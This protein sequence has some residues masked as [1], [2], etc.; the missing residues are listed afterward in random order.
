[1]KR[2]LLISIFS[3]F[4]V[5]EVF[6]QDKNP[7]SEVK[8]NE[9]QLS[10]NVERQDFPTEFKLMQLDLNLFRQSLLGA[11]NRLQSLKSNVIISIPNSDG[12]LER[13]QIFEASNFDAQLQ[14]Q[15][16]E[17]RS[18]VGMGIDDKLAIL[19]M[20]VD[21][22]G[23][24][25]MIFRTDKTN[26]FM[27]PYSSDGKVYA[28]YSSSRIKG[29]LP[30]T[31]STQDQN[32]ANRLSEKAAKQSETLRSSTPELLTFRLALSCTAEYSNYF[33]AT[34]ASQVGLVLAAFNATMTRVNGVFEKDFTIRMNIIANTTSVIY[35]TANSDPYSNSNQ[36]NNWNAQLQNT[37]TNVIGEAN[38]DVGHLFGATGG[39]GNAGCIGCVC[40][41]GSKGSGYTS[42]ANGI[43]SGDT[44]DIDY[45]AHE[46]GH[47]FGANH[48]FSHS[49][50]GS[51]VNMEPGSGST[52]MGY[53]GITAQDVQP[54]SNDYFHYA[55]IF[56]VESNMEGKTCPTRTAIA[57][58]DAPIVN[59]GLNYTIPR[60]TP[61]V[62]TGSASDPN[63]VLSY[64][65]EQ[66][67]NAGS[68]QTGV[69]SAASATKATGPN[70]RSYSPVALPL[71]YFPRIQS[72]I[73]NSATTAGTDITVE[74]LS[75]VNRTLNFAFT[76]RDNVA[77]FGLTNTDA[78]TITVNAAAGPFVVNIPSNNGL[79]YAAGTNQTVTWNVAG[80]TANNINASHVDI[81]MS[82]D[83]GFTYPILL[84]TNVPNDGSE[85]VTIPNNVGTSNRIMVKGYNHVFF[86]I[87]NNNFAITA[88]ASTLSL[89]YG[90][91]LGQQNKSI[92]QGN[93]TSYTLDYAALGGFT[94]TTTFT[95]TGNPA[96]TAV[97]FTPS[98]TN[99]NGL[100]T[101]NVT[102]TAAVPLGN[103]TIVVT[104]TS[105]A[106]TKTV[107]LYLTV[108]SG[109][110]GTQALTSP[111]N[112]ATGIATTTSVSWPSN[113]AAT[114][115]VVE[116]ATDI[117]FTNIIA[118]GVITG[119]TTT[120]SGLA[121]ITDY[122]W[123][124]KP[125]NAGCEGTFSAAFKFTTGQSNCTYNYAN[126]TTLAISDGT[127]A[128]TAGPTA[129]K[130]ITVPGTVV[131][132][133]NAV[134]VG[135]SLTH[136][137]VQDLIIELVHP[138]GTIIKLM[139][140]NCDEGATINGASYT[141]NFTNAG[142]F[143]LPNGSCL[144]PTPITGNVKPAD[145]IT[146]FNGKTAPGVWT[147]RATD[148]WNG[149]V[150][151]IGNWNIKLC[152][153]ETPLSNE[154]YGIDDFVL[155]PNPN[156]GNFNIQFTST[157]G[158]EIKINVHDIRGR[159]IFNKSY[160]NNGLFNESLQLNNVQ[161]GVYLVTVQDGARKEV[162]KI[163]VQ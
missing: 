123:R 114:S 101:V 66:I 116:V 30:F 144:N 16:P 148:W 104:G 27:E 4:F 12:V 129:T 90:G 18:Y 163:V 122:Y 153:A 86:D 128:N 95:A 89:A 110:F 19:R 32:L 105:G 138:D 26:E 58:T 70:W 160:N 65:W 31:C 136:T 85:V 83:G 150:G 154:S 100:V 102:S 21:P 140:R 96:N 38:Y 37:L 50:E 63:G 73:A 161:S 124:V 41:D 1:M 3:L 68:T 53:A 113:A 17:I 145:P 9:F 42:P 98:S 125:I 132:N 133:I 152:M 131:G 69:N 82:L 55:S 92:C 15:F 97:T 67:D 130:T 143:Q 158:N 119:T 81:F 6:A 76:A 2:K 137:Y 5:F 48:T 35:Y 84:A 71:R 33:G 45:V 74:A 79:S 7:W 91:G 40:E 157:T 127:G 108:V 75:S 29:K 93:S 109:N 51:G 78:A 149:D 28:I 155:Y 46:L 11:P 139:N 25:T 88:P 107:N 87:S 49:N 111:A 56:Q 10:K 77:G 22:R 117:A 147:L 106:I 20:S 94:G 99:S 134:E 36:M 162:K 156:N 112:L 47:Q 64:C 52:I 72:V 43:P 121:E 34:S 60:S 61:F 141:F 24:Q 135:I 44:F 159:E 13:F 80:T 142:T 14:A 151:S 57:N 62:L 103:Y 8:N 146:V 120:V 118:T 59:A 23:I 126:N 39:G 54:N 115:Y